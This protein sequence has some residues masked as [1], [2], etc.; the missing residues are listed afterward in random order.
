MAF[1]PL[2]AF[3]K[4]QKI[5]LA[6]I[7]IMCMFIF[8]LQFAPG[9]RGDFFG[10]LTE[11][12]GQGK[13]KPAANLYGK[14]VY[15]FEVEELLRQREI[16]NQY[17]LLAVSRGN[18]LKIK[19]LF[20]D[21]K[22]RPE[23]Q[24]DQNKQIV[25]ELEKMQRSVFELIRAIDFLQSQ[26]DPSK[27]TPAFAQLA[28]LKKALFKNLKITG[29]RR[30]KQPYFGGAPRDLKNLLEFKIWLHEADRLGILLVKKDVFDLVNIEADG[31]LVDDKGKLSEK[32]FSELYRD[33]REQNRN[34]SSDMIVA[35][36]SDEFRVRLAKAALL[37][38]DT[39]QDPLEAVFLGEKPQVP[40]ATTPYELWQF[41]RAQSTKS[42][43]ALVPIPVN[44][45]DLL[46]QVQPPA[47]SAL[48][49][50]FEKS[51]ARE[52][53]PGAHVPGFKQPPRVEAEWVSARVDDPYYR[54]EAD[55]ELGRVRT[56]LAAGQGVLAAGMRTG[57]GGATAALAAVTVSAI[58]AAF[59]LPL[60]HKYDDL[61]FYRFPAPSWTFEWRLTLHDSSLQR[62]ENV[63]VLLGQ[64][65]G[66]VGTRA[67]LLSAPIA[68]EGAAFVR[69]A[70]DRSKIWSALVLAGANPNPLV[71]VVMLLPVT[72]AEKYLP[73]SR[74]REQVAEKLQEGMARELV[75][76]NLRAL[77]EELQ[78][79]SRETAGRAFYDK[80]AYRPAR[81]ALLVGQLVGAAGTGAPVWA[82]PW[83]YA[84]RVIADEFK[85][86]GRWAGATVLAGA[87]LPPL[88]AA[89]LAAEAVNVPRT[90]ARTYLAW[91][92]REYHLHHDGTKQ[93]RNR[94]TIAGDD[95]LKTLKKSHL[96]TRSSDFEQLF[97]PERERPLHFPARWPQI[98]DSM[99]PPPRSHED[100]ER[101]RN[102]NEHVW[103]LDGEPFLYWKTA[104][105][106]AYVPD[107]EEVKDR[108][109]ERWL[110]ENARALAK[111]EADALRAAVAQSKGDA[112]RVL[113]DGGKHSDKPFYLYDVARMV[114]PLVPQVT[115]QT[116]GTY[117]PYQIPR[118]K[119]E[120]P[121]D[122]FLDQ[123]LSLETPG[124]TIVLS[125]KPEAIYYV[126]T[127]LER[128]PPDEKAFYD[129]Y[130]RN[131]GS[132][133]GRLE[134]EK[135]VSQEFRKAVMDRLEQEAHMEFNAEYLKNFQGRSGDMGDD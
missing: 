50:L 25:R 71:P 36:L 130:S 20:D 77:E 109:K 89:A 106:P 52:S 107:F 34:A 67:P 87:T 88:T 126:A 29:L 127:L 121:T 28:L 53:T 135:H 62:A 23:F 131:A 41:F 2:H 3:R 117:Q 6:G 75:S 44:H 42:K 57:G 60:L 13:H 133:F 69:E 47:E 68:Y 124:S 27:P 21:I 108:V 64:M 76:R 32:I 4:R 95:G 114:K 100:L 43:I 5:L 110:F 35:A 73:L 48:R 122:D 17:I 24:T 96:R 14:T 54:A 18:D 63:A 46:A 39:A 55:K 98:D 40:P 31:R 85:E 51:K 8:V 99:M 91:A 10:M 65:M 74:V 119:I 83:G 92:I 125:D 80:S 129:E 22:K 113:M 93:P 78:R 11:S 70:K 90:Q 9:G 12:F 72:P 101:R 15:G 1:N 49:E 104:D 84:T 61:K 115:Q 112:E 132:L 103:I 59:D 102:A 30:G 56:A 58:P 81:V 82:A 123:L 97:F 79:L 116:R 26:L 134:Q 38:Y 86:Q 16:A 19:N 45:K 120:H 94:A 37:G 111:K 128:A 118:E 7:T 33:V 66:A 105:W